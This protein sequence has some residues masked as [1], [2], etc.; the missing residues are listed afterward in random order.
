MS[1]SATG[2]ITST[3]RS[4]FRSIMSGEPKEIRSGRPW[5]PPNRKIRECSR[6]RPTIDVTR[7]PSESP[8]TPARR[9]HRPRTTRSTGTPAAEA[10]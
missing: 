6:N 10:R 5:S 8:G 3:R 7:M 1:G 9:L 2:T 4:R